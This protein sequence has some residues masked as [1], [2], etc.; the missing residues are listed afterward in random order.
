MVSIKYLVQVNLDNA[1]LVMNLLF[2][3]LWLLFYSGSCFVKSAIYQLEHVTNGRKFCGF[4]SLILWHPKNSDGFKTTCAVFNSCNIRIS[5]FQD[6]VSVKFHLWNFHAS[7]VTVRSSK[8]NLLLFL[9]TRYWPELLWQCFL[10]TLQLGI[11]YNP[12]NSRVG[13]QQMPT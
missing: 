4:V 6:F 2:A 7:P 9:C 5:Y 3:Y 1:M 13:I 10:I 11:P 12:R 8:M